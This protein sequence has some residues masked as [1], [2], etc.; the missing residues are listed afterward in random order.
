MTQYRYHNYLAEI[1]SK[2]AIEPI[3][4][5]TGI[6]PCFGYNVISY[7]GTTLFVSADPD[8]NFRYNLANDRMVLSGT[9]SG[10]ITP[11]GIMTTETGVI[12]IPLALGAFSG[13][14]EVFIIANHIYDKVEGGTDVTY[15][16]YVNPD[17][18]GTWGEKLKNESSTMETWLSL[19]DTNLKRNQEVI[20][21]YCKI[22][23]VGND[24]KVSEI[25]NPYHYVWGVSN[26]VSLDRYL[27]DIENLRNLIPTFESTKVQLSNKEAHVTLRSYLNDPDGTTDSSVFTLLEPE[28]LINKLGDALDI[29]FNGNLDCTGSGIDLA[30]QIAITLTAEMDYALPI[31][32]E[33]KWQSPIAFNWLKESTEDPESGQRFC[34]NTHACYGTLSLNDINFTLNMQLFPIKG[35][36]GTV[37]ANL[38]PMMDFTQRIAMMAQLSEMFEVILDVTSQEG[39][40]G[41]GDVSGAG[42]YRR[43][44]IVYITA[45]PADGSGFVG[46]YE[47]NTLLSV[48]Q[49][50]SFEI[51]R[52]VNYIA[53]FNGSSTKVEIKVKVEPEGK[54]TVKGAGM[55]AINTKCTLECTPKSGYGFKQWEMSGKIY[56][57]NPFTFG[58][59]KG[60]NV[61][62]VLSA[63]KRNLTLFSNPTGIMN[64]TGAGAYEVG[65]DV[66]VRATVVNSEYEFK[67]WYKNSVASANF[68]SSNP[69]YSFKMPDANLA[70]MAFAELKP[71]QRFLITAYTS[72]SGY[73]SGDGWYEEGETV[74]LRATGTDG[75]SFSSWTGDYNTSENPLTFTATRTITVTA[76]FTG[77]G[78]PEPDQVYIAT[79]VSPSGAGTVTGGGYYDYGSTVRLTA[80]ASAN[81]KFSYWSGASIPDN[82]PVLFTA[83]SDLTITANFREA[84]S[85]DTYYLTAKANNDLY[86]T[87]SGGGSYPAGAT[88]NVKATP[89]SGYKFS[90]WS[91]DAV[92]D[93]PTLTVIMNK[94]RT[95]TANFVA[96]A[97]PGTKYHLTVNVSTVDPGGTVT[98]AGDYDAGTYANPQAYP[99]SGKT[100]KYWTGDNIFEQPGNTS[101]PMMYRMNR[102]ATITAHF[103]DAEPAYVTKQISI[104]NET[105]GTIQV[106]LS[107]SLETTNTQSILSGGVASWNVKVPTSG[108]AAWIVNCDKKVTGGRVYSSAS[109]EISFSKSGS[110][111]WVI[112]YGGGTRNASWGANITS[113]ETPSTVST[114]LSFNFELDGGPITVTPS[115]NLVSL[116]LP[117]S[118]QISKQNGKTYTLNSVGNIS[119]SLSAPG[120]NG[121]TKVNNGNNVNISGSGGSYSISGTTSNKGT[122]YIYFT[123]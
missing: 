6:G 121:A 29:F 82:N 33:A 30:K 57:I 55:Y 20:L 32:I 116:G 16:A 91:G 70:L 108:G 14:K 7:D 54:G 67:G 117:S 120:T 58:V 50:Y 99:N 93:N 113:V 78:T 15:R 101:N 26:Y 107:S 81:Y 63:P 86:G 17:S 119:G 48:E 77:G 94:N 8:K 84:G 64:L 115:S 21:A 18:K 19:I 87:V 10:C 4:L 88:A 111:N 76:N 105:S 118:F 13:Y 104:G 66:T 3:A 2:K 90:N 28:L 79:K 123:K 75:A 40:T 61:V 27:T 41:S 83:T 25:R 56:D 100:F 12:S 73:V 69:N 38:K 72:G 51:Q 74:T 49:S 103:K 42:K 43:G 36:Q 11:D 92:G 106:S 22:E 35:N 39:T 85:G 53:M 34:Q 47:G 89:K 110:D 9:R 68:L 60:E 114:T 80:N 122:T 97:P 31:P 52:S 24:H 95:I 37:A 71:K 45:S 65:K 109:S 98:G 112:T 5:G 1:R 96:D 46:W 23:R 44:T 59:S 62:C 102:N